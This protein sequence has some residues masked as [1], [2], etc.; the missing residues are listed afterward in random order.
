MDISLVGTISVNALQNIAS[1]RSAERVVPPFGYGC[2]LNWVSLRTRALYY[3]M[4]GHRATY[5]IVE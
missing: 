5:T 1:V 2:P 4:K 3:D